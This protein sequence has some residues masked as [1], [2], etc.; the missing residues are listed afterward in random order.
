MDSLGL[1]WRE[2]GRPLVTG[3]MA[4]T[5]H[6]VKVSVTGA[7][8]KKEDIFKESTWNKPFSVSVSSHK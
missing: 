4:V 1:F 3:P 5:K 2:S 6:R 7:G 8:D